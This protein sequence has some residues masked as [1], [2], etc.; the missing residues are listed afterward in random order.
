MPLSQERWRPPSIGKTGHRLQRP[1]KTLSLLVPVFNEEDAIDLFMAELGPALEEAL[2][3]LAPHGNHEIVF[4]DD[5]SNDGTVARIL[6]HTAGAPRVR[7]VRLSRNFGKDAALAAGLHFAAGDAVIPIDVDLQD[8]P[9]V[10]SSMVAAWINGAEVVNA[11]RCDRRSDGWLKRWSAKAFYRVYN[12]LATDSIPGNVG[13]FRLLDRKVVDVLNDFSERN[14]FMKGVFSWVGFEQT[15][16]T[17]ERPPRAAG[18]TKWKFWRLWNFAL[19]GL[20]ASTTAPLRIWTYV[21]LAVALGAIG[22]A[23]FLVARTLILGIDVPGY[24]SLMT[25]ILTLGALNLISIGILGE[26]IGRIAIEV[27]QRPLY[28]VR[29]TYGFD[30][31]DTQKSSGGKQR[32]APGTAG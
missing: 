10:I 6:A 28:V 3:R 15:T 24:A 14:R 30:D 31:T 4:I 11:R 20:T 19:D 9:E 2:L 26:Y 18:T 21:G 17:Y 32:A 12:V 22:Y 8:P 5:G 27:R 1:D 29:D 7:L 23:I 16:I 13:D 25:L